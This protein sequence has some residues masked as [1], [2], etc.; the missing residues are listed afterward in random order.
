VNEVDDLVLSR[1]QLVVRAANAV[2]EMHDLLASLGPSSHRQEERE[3]PAVHG[4]F[5]EVRASRNHVSALITQDE[6][7]EWLNIKQRTRLMRKLQELKIPYVLGGGGRICT[8]QKAIDSGL[9]GASVPKAR[10][11]F[12]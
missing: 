11:E 7:Q 3:G 12:A 1:T 9:T 6:L 5:K 2:Y 4:G 10:I 8:T